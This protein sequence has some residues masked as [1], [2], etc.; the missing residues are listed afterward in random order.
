MGPAP[1][2]DGEGGAERGLARGESGSGERGA[3]GDRLTDGERLNERVE[4]TEEELEECR[5]RERSRLR[6]SSA[7]RFE[8]R[9]FSIML[10][11]D[12]TAVSSASRRAA[13]P[14]L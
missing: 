12:A 7:C 6:S 8:P 5:A 9:S 10:W 3:V 11:I 4:E 1:E 2:Y 14:S 13:S